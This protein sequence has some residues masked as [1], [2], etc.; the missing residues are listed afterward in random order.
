VKL[1]EVPL[2]SEVVLTGVVVWRNSNQVGLRFRSH[3]GDL[4]EWS[5]VCSVDAEKRP[6]P[7]ELTTAVLSAIIQE[8]KP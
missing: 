1:G 6:Y 3:K 7:S 2:G 4:V 5:V 8:A